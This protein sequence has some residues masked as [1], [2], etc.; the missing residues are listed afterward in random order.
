M[1]IKSIRANP[2]SSNSQSSPSRFNHES[3]KTKAFDQNFKTSPLSK[4]TDIKVR[5]KLELE[6]SQINIK[7]RDFDT[8]FPTSPDA[9]SENKKIAKI[10]FPISPMKEQNLP[11]VRSEIK[12]PSFAMPKQIER[13]FAGQDA[14]VRKNRSLS[15]SDLPKPDFSKSWAQQS[16]VTESKSV[17]PTPA[18]K[19]VAKSRTGIAPVVS[20]FQKQHEALLTN[21]FKYKVTYLAKGSFSNVYTLEDNKDPIIDGINNSELVLKAYHG[22]NSGFSEKKLRAFLRNQIQ[23]FHATVN[24]GLPVG[25][26][27]NAETAEQDGYIIQQ[28]ISGKIDPLNV[29]QLFQVSRFFDVADKQ[30]LPM[31][32]QEQNFALENGRVILIDF[33]ED[34]EDE[35][36]L[37]SFTKTVIETSWLKFYKEAG[38]E[39]QQTV[40]FLNILSANHYQQFIQELISK[41]L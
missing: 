13:V 29:E 40:D 38:V 14:V 24:A 4:K 8:V 19:I 20:P 31:D 17:Q 41:Y 5:K 3:N 18:K 23:N 33:I 36:D 25:V 37:Q 2:N 6:S 11:S 12:F 1:T 39:K 22:E 26:I 34:P 27:Y 9:S 32:L 10:A 7:K 28:K 15:T 16:G 21:S 30:N 35:D